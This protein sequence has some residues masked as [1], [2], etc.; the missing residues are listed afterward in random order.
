MNALLKLHTP[1]ESDNSWVALLVNALDV[2]LEGHESPF[3]PYPGRGVC[4]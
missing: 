2:T 1:G 3:C 4:S